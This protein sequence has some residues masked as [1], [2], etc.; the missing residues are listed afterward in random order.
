MEEF[1]RREYRNCSKLLKQLEEKALTASLINKSQASSAELS[2][3]SSTSK[4]VDQFYYDYDTLRRNGLLFAAVMII[5]G[6][7]VLVDYSFLKRITRQGKA[8]KLA[9]SRDQ[10]G[11]TSV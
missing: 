1:P 9:A 11:R 3:E 7:F 10:K 8:R 6:M 4:V 5:I 2:M